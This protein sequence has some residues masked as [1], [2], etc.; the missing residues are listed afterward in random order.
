[1][2]YTYNWFWALFWFVPFLLLLWG[3]FAWNGRRYG[4]YGVRYRSLYDDDYDDDMWWQTRRNRRRR[5][6]GRGP[7]NYRRSD[8]RILEDVSDRL[9]VCDEVDASDIEVQVDQG[10]VTLTGTVE[11]R[12]EKRRAEMVSDWVPG[13]IDVD[14]RLRLGR[15]IQSTDTSSTNAPVSR[16]HN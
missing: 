14:N 13:V 10:K 12:R 8:A 3:I 2:F 6:Y 16:S 15:A 1:M 9:M 4:D 7:R 11:S 5:H